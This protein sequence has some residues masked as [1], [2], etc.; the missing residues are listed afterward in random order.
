MPPTTWEAYQLLHDGALALQR[1]EEQGMRIDVEYCKRKMNVLDRKIERI[2]TKIEPDKLIKLWRKIYGSKFNVN[3]NAQLANILYSKMHIEPLKR[4]ETG[5]GSTDDETLTALNIPTLNNILQIRKLRKVRDTYLGAFIREQVDGILHPFFNLNTVV[6]FRSSSSNINFQNVPK[7]DEEA[8]QLVRSAIL[9]R[10]GHQLVELD[11][12]TL[13]VLISATYHH[14]KNLIYDATQG[15]MHSDMAVE[16]FLL[17]A[18][19]KRVPEL[20]HLRDATKNGFVFPQFYGDYYKNN[21]IYLAKKWGNLPIGRWKPEMGVPMPKGSTL[22]RHLIERGITSYEKFETHLQKIE[23]YFWKVRYKK[24]GKWREDWVDEYREKGYFDMHTGFRCKG[25]MSRNDVINYPVQGAAFHCLLWSF[26]Q[27]DKR[28]REE[29]WDTRLIGQIHDAIVMDVPP[30]ELEYVIKTAQ[31]VM[32]QEIRDYWEWIT[33]PL[34]IEADV[35]DIDA[36]WSE[37]HGYE[38]A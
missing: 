29:S 17:D 10:P 12:G 7:R 9:P 21:A 6:T 15:D 1:A 34:T 33:V 3:S 2:T 25:V 19:D 4:T 32:C 24:Y 16:I 36:P 14:D 20:K 26:I 22:G 27:L 28:M 11:Y 30:K 31:Q 5:Q 38:I 18:M 37:K 13:E 8:M 23:K 35:C